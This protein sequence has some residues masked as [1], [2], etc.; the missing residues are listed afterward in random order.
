MYSRLF[1]VLC[2][3]VTIDVLIVVADSDMVSFWEHMTLAEW[4]LGGFPAW[5][6]AIEPD[7]R[8]RSSD[9]AYLQM[10]CSHIVLYL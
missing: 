9:P 8:L 4:D 6:L 2:V 5:L 1:L 7:V 3:P 10:V